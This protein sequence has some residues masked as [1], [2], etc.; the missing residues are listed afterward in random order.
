MNSKSFI[1]TRHKKDNKMREGGTR[2]IKTVVDAERRKKK[3]K[4]R[5]FLFLFDLVG[6]LALFGVHAGIII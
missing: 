6:L 1:Q 5:L 4:T 2:S 3:Q